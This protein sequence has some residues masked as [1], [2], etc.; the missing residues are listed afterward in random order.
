MLAIA[1]AKHHCIISADELNIICA[2]GMLSMI[3]GYESWRADLRAI[4]TSPH[5]L[6]A[7]LPSLLGHPQV[8]GHDL[9]AGMSPM[10]P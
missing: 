2:L 8:I 5:H 3:S 6:H 4:I 10:S 7:P 9:L 1:S